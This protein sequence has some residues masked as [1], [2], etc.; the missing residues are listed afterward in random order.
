MNYYG[1]FG[2][3]YKQPRKQRLPAVIDDKDFP[4]GANDPLP[5]RLGLDVRIS[6]IAIVI[7]G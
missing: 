5:K 4:S 3:L 7:R 1:M 6:L 2:D